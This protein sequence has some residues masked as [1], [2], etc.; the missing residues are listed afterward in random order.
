MRLLV[1]GLGR[2]GGAVVSRAVREGHEVGYVERRDDGADVAAAESQGATRV[3]D[4]SAWH[5][6]LCVAAPGVPLTH[7]DLVRLVELGTEVIGEVEWIWRTLP[8][9]IVGIT[10]TAGKGTVTRWLTDV[11]VRS[12]VDAVAGGNIVPAL[13]AVARPGATLVVELSSFQ[14]ERCPTLRP[15]VAVV[16]NLGVDHLDRHGDVESYHAAKRALISHLGPDQVFVHNADDPRV[17]AWAASTPAR[18]APYTLA[19]SVG[20]RVPSAARLD[21]RTLVLGDAP[22]LDVAEL[23]VQGRHQYGNALAVALAAEALGVERRVIAE[24]LRAFP[25][26]PGRYA[27]VGTLGG[28]RFFEDSIATR[29]LA[30]EAALETTPGPIVWIAG[31]VDK[32]SD[33]A[34]L[35][36]LLRDKVTLLLGIGSSGP[37]ITAAA[38]WIRAEVVA[39]ADGR[40]M[41]RE[42]VRR[43]WEH[44]QAAHAGRG[45]VLLA[46]LAASFDQ[47]RDYVDRADAYRDAVAALVDDVRMLALLR[48]EEVPWTPSS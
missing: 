14:L 17:V 41:L 20:A 13:A 19:P 6:D 39:T 5:A 8:A 2:S 36:H 26:L 30:V 21:G 12:G 34:A 43:A 40:A 45:S 23:R 29:Q 3:R 11:L 27:E 15:D 42:A 38:P 4:V 16:L 33:V 1:Y 28:V 44:L 18:T 31:G 47:F 35:E 48:D 32:G 46:P 24:G 9:R 37:T 10:G 22:L 7:P 25:G